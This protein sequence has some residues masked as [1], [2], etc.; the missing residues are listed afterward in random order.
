M[1]LPRKS[2]VFVCT[3]SYRLSALLKPPSF[4]KK[5]FFGISG[6][7]HIPHH[8]SNANKTRNAFETSPLVRCLYIQLDAIDAL[9]NDATMHRRRCTLPRNTE[10]KQPET[11]G[12]LS[13][14]VT[15]KLARARKRPQMLSVK[16][17]GW[18]RGSCTGCDIPCCCEVKR[19][20]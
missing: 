10:G 13:Y 9:G 18:R 6:R 11:D 2:L 15:Q 12:M 17:V 20:G 5:Y 1:A 4:R 8:N 14:L 7:L 16:G 3:L 19:E